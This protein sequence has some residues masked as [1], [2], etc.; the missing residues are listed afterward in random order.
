[1]AGR[2]IL[3]A[4]AVAALAMVGLAGPATA[5]DRSAQLTK[6]ASASAS[7][8]LIDFT[9]AQVYTYS[10]TDQTPQHVLVVR[11]IQPY[12]NME[13][14]LVPLVYIR[15]P[16]YWGIEVMGCLSGVGLPA[17]KPYV[18]K[19]DLAGTIGTRGIEVIGATRS[20]KIEIPLFGS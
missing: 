18:A 1:M 19:L 11:G 5:D 20:E 6:A 13:V 8:Q 2:R 12:R 4:I 3:L 17:T 10:S 16:E 9:S 14:K 7:C 15:Q